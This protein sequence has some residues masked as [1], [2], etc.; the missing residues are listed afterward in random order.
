MSPRE[1]G[2]FSTTEPPSGDSL[3][4][5]WVQYMSKFWPGFLSFWFEFCQPPE[6]P[7]GNKT[8]SLPWTLV[9][10]AHIFLSLP[11]FSVSQAPL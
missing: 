5:M 3:N 11:V 9:K 4:Q 1:V 7:H 6:V 10:Q 8:I 2:L